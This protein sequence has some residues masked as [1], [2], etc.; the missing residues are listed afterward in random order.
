MKYIFFLITFI[1]FG[2]FAETVP[3]ENQEAFDWFVQFFND[4]YEVVEHTPSF[5]ER[6]FAF[7]IQFVIYIKYALMLESIEFA[8]GVA[9]SLI[10]NIGL[11][12]L[13]SDA[14]ARL[15]SEYRVSFQAMGILKSISML[16]EALMVRFVL[17][18]MGW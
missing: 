11:D 8:Y 3:N 4:I 1:S 18:F 14:I 9:Q 13:I 2:V 5:F 12:S 17:N 7:F 15:P 16:C 6:C 10:I